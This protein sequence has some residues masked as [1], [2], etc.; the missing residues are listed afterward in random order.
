MYIVNYIATLLALV[1]SSAAYREAGLKFQV[2]VTGRDVVAYEAA[3]DDNSITSQAHADAVFPYTAATQYKR[4]IYDKA[5]NPSQWFVWPEEGWEP[6]I[7][8]LKTLPKVRHF[9]K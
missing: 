8:F 2:V 9:S 5:F 1:C 3:I 7:S 6:E 4:L